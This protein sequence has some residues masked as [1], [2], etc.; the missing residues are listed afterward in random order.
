VKTIPNTNG[1]HGIALA[2]SFNKGFISCGKDNAVVIF[3]LQTLETT[4]TLPISGK[5]PDAILYDP[6]SKRVFTFNGRSSNATVINAETDKVEGTIEL[7]GKPEF[8]V[9]DLKGKIYVNIEDKSTLIEIDPVK[10][11]VIRS[12]TIAPGI[13]PSGLAIDLLS[14]KLFSVCDNKLM[15]VSDIASGNVQDTVIIGERVDGVAYDAGVS[16]II[17]SNGEGNCTIIQQNAQGKY[18]AVQKLMTQKGARTIAVNPKTHRFYTPT[19]E[20]G[21]TPAAT[22]ENPRPRPSLKPGTFTV[23]EIGR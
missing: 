14:R 23:L 16:S 17:S 5:N 11:Q 21:E 1:V 10:L 20:F 6:F 2:Y 12:W 4:S 3:N 9:S 18:I 8:A 19:A 22:T 13:E 15:V 7:S